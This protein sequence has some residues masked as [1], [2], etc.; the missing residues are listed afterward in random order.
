MISKFDKNNDGKL[1]E[2]EREAIREYI[3]QRMSR[4]SR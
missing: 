2:K 1:D 4:S 3:K